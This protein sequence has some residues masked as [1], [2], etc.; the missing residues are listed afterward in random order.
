MTIC[1]LGDG[2]KTQSK[3]EEGLELRVVARDSKRLAGV[4]IG[5]LRLPSRVVNVVLQNISS[6]PLSFH[7]ISKESIIYVFS[8]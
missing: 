1:S 5:K 2:N 3:I 7:C 6:S 8:F 4:E